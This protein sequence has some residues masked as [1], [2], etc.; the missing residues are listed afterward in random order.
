VLEITTS[1]FSVNGGSSSTTNSIFGIPFSVK[2]RTAPTGISY[3]LA[4]SVA[5]YGGAGQTLT[6]ITFSFGTVDFGQILGTV[7]AG[8]ITNTP[9]VGALPKI[10]FTGCEL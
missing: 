6:N 7:A 3:T 4:G 2:A 1:G 10:I 9:C 8:L 5:N